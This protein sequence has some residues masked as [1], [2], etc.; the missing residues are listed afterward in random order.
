MIFFVSSQL[1]MWITEI[2]MMGF[3]IA[4]IGGVICN[5]MGW[6]WRMIL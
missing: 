3:Y 6:K 2:V 1:P 4:L 5:W